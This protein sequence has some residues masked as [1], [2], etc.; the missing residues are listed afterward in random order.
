MQSKQKILFSLVK[1]KNGNCN[2]DIKKHLVKYQNKRS[3]NNKYVEIGYM[4]IA[5]KVI[6]KL[7]RN[8]TDFSKFL[9]KMSKLK[10]TEGIVNH[11]GYTSVGDLKRLKSTRRLF[12]N[13]NYFLVD[14]DGVL[15]V[16]LKKDM[17]QILLS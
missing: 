17:S 10:L 2:F 9:V 12:S 8:D 13:N 16:S 6:E 14:R 4:I 5:K 11:H 15:N 1:K 3:K 7:R